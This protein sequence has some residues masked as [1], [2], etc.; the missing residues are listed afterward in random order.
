MIGNPNKVMR[1]DIDISGEQTLFAADIQTALVNAEKEKDDLFLLVNETEAQLKLL[2]PE[3]DKI[4]YALAASCGAL[5]GIVD[6]FLVGDPTNSPLG[7]LNDK[8]IE[9]R[10]KIFAKILGWDEKTNSNPIAFLEKK[11]KVP[12]DQ[13]T[14]GEASKEVFNLTPSNHHFK[15]LSH[16]PT[17][18]GLFFSILDQF[19]NESHFVSDDQLIILED[20]SKTFKLKGKTVPTKILAGI[21]NWIGHLISDASGSSSSS[22]RGMGVPSPLWT[23][24]NDVIAI[25]NK[26]N[27]PVSE[28]EKSFNELAL[29]IYLKGYDA[30][31]QSTQAIPVL[32]NELLVRFLYSARRMI[33]YYS[34]TLPESR[35]IEDLWSQCEPFKNA[36]VKR[37]LTVAHGSFCMVDIGDAM[38]RSISPAGVN[39]ETLVMR[40]NIVGIGRFAISLY[41]EGSSYI[42]R[43]VVVED[44]DYLNK[45]Q[46][47]LDDY[48][49]GLRELSDK[50]DDIEI[51]RFINDFIN[52][53]FYKE[54]FNKSVELAEKREVP[55][56]VILRSKDDIDRYF[57]GG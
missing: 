49:D 10:V 4:D 7:K 12:Y 48:I 9:G 22:G 38:V 25:K 57:R 56:D 52:S 13:S 44:L 6:V 27:L 18:L 36:T 30:R 24:M 23:W 16:N 32:I 35:S 34:V 40:I 42:E 46:I 53:S 45:K 26:L 17:I 1:I 51:N 54:A 15:S 2:T 20:A 33:R 39:V 28:F 29:K 47:I 14:L 43:S 31:F 19:C 11:F 21:V 3:C 41:G 8:W 50:Y 5:C 37:M 55:D